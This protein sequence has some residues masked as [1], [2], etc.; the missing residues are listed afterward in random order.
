[1]CFLTHSC[2]ILYLLKDY[3][4]LVIAKFNNYRT[5]T[6]V[7]DK[8]NI[9]TFSTKINTSITLPDLPTKKGY[10]ASWDNLDTLITEDKTFTVIYTPKKYTITYSFENEEIE[11]YVQEVTYGEE[12]GRSE[13]T[14]P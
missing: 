5:V 14:F 4:I 12:L 1:M 8:D 6:I 3:N 11:N 13:R 7:L 10:D 9:Q 2:Y